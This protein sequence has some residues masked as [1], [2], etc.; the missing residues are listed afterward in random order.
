MLYL[1]SIIFIFTTDSRK[2]F[3]ERIRK[4]LREG[5][6]NNFF[7]TYQLAGRSADIY[8]QSTQNYDDGPSEKKSILKSPRNEK[9]NDFGTFHRRNCPKKQNTNNTQKP[10]L[11][12]FC[13]CYE[14]TN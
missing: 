2:N 12:I 1:S 11:G 8:A 14:T 13:L 6:Y 9:Q 5:C 4:P 3:N 7:T 10:N